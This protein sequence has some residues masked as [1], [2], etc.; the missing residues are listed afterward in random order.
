MTREEID[1][2]IYELEKTY[3]VDC[4]YIQATDDLDQDELRVRPNTYLS[5][6]GQ[7]INKER[8]LEELDKQD[9]IRF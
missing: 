4:I 8:I 9:L 2:L 3:C 1:K 5:F 7:G 6:R